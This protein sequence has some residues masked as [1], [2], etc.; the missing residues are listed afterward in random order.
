MIAVG[1]SEWRG[2]VTVPKGGRS[3]R[4]PMTRQLA[5]VLH[6]LRHLR[7]VRVFWREDGSTTMRY[8]HLSPSAQESA[9]KTLEDCASTENW[10]G[11][12]DSKFR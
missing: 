3:R 6:G 5:Q 10:R 4:V 11:V 8:M 1:P 2:Q 9:V 12:R 7:S